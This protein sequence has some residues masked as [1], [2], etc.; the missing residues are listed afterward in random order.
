MVLAAGFG[1][2]LRPLTEEV[3][4][5]LVPVLGRP[6]VEHTVRMLAAW[7]V[8]RIVMN[9]HH[10][11]E[12]IPA[13]LGDGSGLGVGIEYCV[14]EP[15]I[16]GTGGGVLN[17]RP[18]L[19]GAGT[20]LVVNGAVHVDREGRVRGLLGAPDLAGD[21]SVRPTMFTGIHLL[22][23][24]V[25]DLLPRSGC[26]VRQ[27]YRR[28]ID[29]GAVV[30]GHVDAGRWVELGTPADYLRANLAL[31]SGALRLSHV[32]GGQGC[33]VGEGVELGPSG[34]LAA[35]VVVGARARVRAPVTRAV[36]WDDV[37]VDAPV[38]DAVVTPRGKTKIQV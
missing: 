18:L 7:G 22:E 8:D 16:L 21:P 29:E 19:D 37:V 27:T 14:E 32:A 15:E 1:T 2:R 17:A 6:L 33:W 25:F 28:L 20:F 5:P 10:L 35:P 13:A 30:S 38:A 4:K 23:P 26:I 24:E 36:L 9:L 34:R 12:A 3:P 11:P 31:A